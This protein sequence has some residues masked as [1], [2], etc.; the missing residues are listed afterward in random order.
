MVC[1][2]DLYHFW[3]LEAIMNDIRGVSEPDEYPQRTR[4]LGMRGWPSFYFETIASHDM[5][6]PETLWSAMGTFVSHSCSDPRDRVFG[7]L[8]LADSE[9]RDAF[10]PDYTKS[11]TAVLLQLIEFH[12][13][14]DKG[15]DSS[16]NFFWAHIIIGAFGLGPDEPDIASMR[17]RRRI[18]VHGQDPFSEITVATRDLQPLF[19]RENDP[20][21]SRRLPRDH[22]SHHIVLDA[23]SHCTVWKNDAGEFIVPLKMPNRAG[24]P[25]RRKISTGQENTAGG[26]KLRTPNGT[27]IGLANQQIQHG[28]TILL[29]ESGVNEGIFHSALIVRRYGPTIATI[30]GQCIV[31]SDLKSC[32]GGSGCVFRGAMHISD[33]DTWRALMSPEDLLVFVAQDLK[34]VPRLPSYS[35]MPVMDVSVQP[36]MSIERVTT[37]VTS[38]EMSS[39]A[40]AGR[41]PRESPANDCNP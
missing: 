31:D 1:G 3:E 38:E 9:C 18:A 39:Y 13:E 7:L 30:V 15:D 29:F 34:A 14:T 22:G 12:A 2:N 16:M 41:N 25:S 37:R 35:G 5:T 20:Y 32:W 6:Y 17:D 33:S 36:E 27:V 23:I 40:I 21:S 19:I 10:R 8:A 4:E 11:A 24:N 26:I 28:D